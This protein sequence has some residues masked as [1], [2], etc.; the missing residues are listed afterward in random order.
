LGAFSEIAE[1]SWALDTENLS[2]Y[3]FADVSIRGL[4][5]V[6]VQV[7]T[8]EHNW[9][10]GVWSVTITNDVGEEVWVDG[11]AWDGQWETTNMIFQSALDSGRTIS[12]PGTADFAVAVAAYSELSSS[13]MGS[14]S[15]GPRIDGAPKPNV[16]APGDNIRAARNSVGV[17]WDDKEGTS[18]A[19]P[20]IAGVLALIRQASGGDSP[21]LD[22]S[23]LVNGAGGKTA[24]YESPSILWGHGLSDALWS[25][26]QVLDSPGTDGAVAS[27]WSDVDELFSDSTDPSF[28]G[29]HDITSAKY[30][31]DGDTIGFVTALRN[32]PDLEGT[33]VL[34]IKWDNDSN[35][36]T[37][38]N[39]ADI[40]V[41]ITGGSA[42]VFEWAGSSYV[43]S[44]LSSTW[45][46][47]SRSVI[48][49]LEG[50]TSGSRG[51]ISMSTHNSTMPLLIRLVLEQSLIHFFL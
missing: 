3:V 22:Y 14:S 39:G 20:H 46:V 16:A 19:S 27:D 51:S 15:R 28:N 38:Q 29:G 34:S 13:I 50:I 8:A 26:R 48:L 7:S 32:S 6:I 37:G 40:V 9:Q 44:S 41:N 31:L 5:N 30:F 4:N 1:S 45:W 36:G 21:W 2:A 42:E 49:R 24:H 10:N 25:V 43:A 35:V 47:N 12:S 17:L 23:A 18:M 11:F 33:D